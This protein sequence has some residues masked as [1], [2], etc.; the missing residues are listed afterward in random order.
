MAFAAHVLALNEVVGEVAHVDWSTHGDAL[1]ARGPFDLVLA[2]DVPLHAGERGLAT[3]LF[4]AW[5]RPEGGC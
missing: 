4:R 2:A 1:V 3:D 5:S